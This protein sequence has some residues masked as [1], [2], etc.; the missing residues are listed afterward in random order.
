MADETAFDPSAHTLAE[1]QEY[2]KTADDTETAR[3]LAAEADGKARKGVPSPD[4]TPPA[5]DAGAPPVPTPEA[6]QAARDA[7][8]A[9]LANG[10]D[11]DPSQPATPASTVAE[12]GRTVTWGG[13]VDILVVAHQILAAD[14]GQVSPVRGD[15]LL[16][17]EKTAD[18]LVAIGAA[19][20]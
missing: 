11:D 15:R 9:A 17:D 20:K 12:T 13:D 3:V 4:P 1:V 7:A 6:V 19:S 8:L 5:D 10:P 18:R 16:T 14:L 2:L